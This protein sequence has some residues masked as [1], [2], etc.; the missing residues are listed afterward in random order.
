MNTFAETDTTME[1]TKTQTQTTPH[2]KTLGINNASPK[3]TTINELELDEQFDVRNISMTLKNKTQQK[4]II[5][6]DKTLVSFVNSLLSLFLSSVYL[7]LI[8]LLYQYFTK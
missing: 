7:Y 8:F 1:T 3:M 5:S 4:K 2:R 6:L